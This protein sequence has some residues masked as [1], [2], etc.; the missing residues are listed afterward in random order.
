MEP[1]LIEVLLMQVHKYHV[2][3]IT[4]HGVDHGKGKKLERKIPTYQQSMQ[5]RSLLSDFH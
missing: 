2:T 5:Y 4:R 3:T 1:L